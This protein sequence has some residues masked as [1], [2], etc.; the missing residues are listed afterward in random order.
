[1]KVY[2]AHC[3]AL[4]DTPQERRDIELLQALGF[5]VVNPNTPEDTERYKTE[6]MEY[7]LKY[8][9]I[10]DACVFR[11][12]PDGAIPAGVF[13]EIQW[14]TEAKKPIFELPSGINR[15]ELTRNQTVEYLH[16]VGQR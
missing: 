10:C 4:Y 6:G 1:M 15:R 3:V 5:E 16:E 8:V 2:Y 12:L 9:S 13:R 11:A 14:F 7:F